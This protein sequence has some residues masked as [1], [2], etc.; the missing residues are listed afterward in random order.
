MNLPTTIKSGVILSMV[1]ILTACQTT[2]S[3]QSPT[4]STQSQAVQSTPKSQLPPPPEGYTAILIDDL[5]DGNRFNQFRGTWFTYDDRYDGGDS[6]V[7]PEGYSPFRPKQ[8][9]PANSDKCAHITGQVTTTYPDG[10][11]GMGTDLN[12]PNDPIDIRD[13]D[14]I[15]FWAKGDG[16][17]YRLK[18]RSPATSDYDDYGYNLTPTPEWKRYV[19][20]LDSLKQEGTGKPV[21]ADEALSQVISIT[22]HTQGQPHDSIELAVDNL[23]F[24]KSQPE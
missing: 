18:L 24:L 14:A 16:K 8:C 15:A 1:I 17:T 11:I 10:Y 12:N 3:T 7:N 5:E 23:R 4:S 9:G 2:S 13:Y 21:S 20:T 22:W 19:I 6:Q